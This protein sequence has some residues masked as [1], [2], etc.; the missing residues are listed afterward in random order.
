MDKKVLEQYTSLVLERRELENKILKIEN[1]IR[2]MTDNKE[3]VKDSVKGG[4]GGIQHFVIEGFPSKM[5]TEK[6]NTL[7]KRRA[8]LLELEIKI[9]KCI[10]DVEEFI[11][12]IDDSFMRRIVNMRILEEKSWSQVAMGVGGGNTED[13]VKQAYRRFLEKS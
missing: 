11:S 2:K 1:E 10:T 3:T 7:R 5:Y 4:N 6:I 13:S 8:M 9:E 12:G